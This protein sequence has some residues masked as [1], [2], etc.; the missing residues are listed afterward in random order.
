M[1][2]ANADKDNDDIDSVKEIEQPNVV[3]RERAKYN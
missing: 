1:A 2:A 3:V